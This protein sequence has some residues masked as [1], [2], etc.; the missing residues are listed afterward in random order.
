MWAGKG[1]KMKFFAGLFLIWIPLFAQ[2]EESISFEDYDPPSTLIV[3]EHTTTHSKFPLIDVHNHQWNI[4]EQDLEELLAEMDKLN[5]AVMV[6]LSGKSFRR[7]AK[8]FGHQ[9]VDYLKQ[10]VDRIQNEAT[11][12]IVTFT[13]I[14]FSEMGKEDWIE[15]TLKELETD[16]GN[17]AGGFF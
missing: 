11:G 8:G 9:G 4:P 3:A 16:A 1:E 7:T 6:N 15:N 13:N 17:G 2:N 10:S 12:R 5:M 14:D